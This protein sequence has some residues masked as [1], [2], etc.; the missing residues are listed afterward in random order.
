MYRQQ[1]TRLGLH[2][3]TMCRDTRK[4]IRKQIIFI[5]TKPPAAA[6][7]AAAAVAA[8]VAAVVAAAVSSGGL[9]LSLFCLR[10]K[11][12]EVQQRAAAAACS[13]GGV[14]LAVN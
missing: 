7:A 13:R 2:A 12:R 14:C 8:V 6:A 3:L 10:T 9:S 1:N 11:D 4:R 5:P